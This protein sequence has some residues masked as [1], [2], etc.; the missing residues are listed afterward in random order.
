[1]N[2]IEQ[3]YQVFSACSGVTTDS[4][5]IKRGELFIALKGDRFDGNRYAAQALEQGASYAVV[6]DPAVADG[7]QYLLVEDTLKAL[8]GLGRHHRRQ[9]DIPVLGVTG[10]NGKTTT[11]ELVAA[12]LAQKY[13]LHFTQGNF[14]NHIGVPLTLLAMPADT[15]FAV[16]EMGA[17]HQG[18]IDELS[19]IAEPSC[20]LITNIGKAHLE[21]FGGIEGVKKGKSELYRFLA[22]VNG[23]VFINQDERFLEDLAAPCEWQTGYGSGAWDATG[24]IPVELT[25]E[26]PF[27]TFAFR[28]PVSG[29]R[30]ES[31]SKLIGRYNFNN[32]MTAVAMG[33]HFEVPGR[34]IKTAVE[35]YLPE[36]MR[37]Q[38][39]ERGGNTYFMD[40]YNANPTSMQ[41]AMLAFAQM[42]ANRRIAILGEM[43]ELGADSEMEHEA[44]IQLAL[45]Q[46]FEAT[47]L[48]GKAFEAP[49]KAA[50]LPHFS[51]VEALRAWFDDQQLQGVHIM[52]KGS[53]SN[54]L[55][56]LLN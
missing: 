39:L 9:F 24:Y 26:Q 38:I 22:E 5:K 36:N 50:G 4:R 35:A 3:L 43:L 30:V 10:S 46:P 2:S 54:K 12:V 15:Q 37:T 49:A 27:L 31:G 1:M 42:D 53:R 44:I 56:G 6:D 13:K 55:E 33:V 45:E 19:R 34:K 28:D 14:N 48:V 47:L 8:Q 23:L 21:G 16:I 51:N 41:N 29:K 25:A 7:P 20:G 32:I 40:A 11:K 17:N 18:E 52:I